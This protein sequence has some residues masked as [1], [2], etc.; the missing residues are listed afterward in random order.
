MKTPEVKTTGLQ[1]VVFAD[2]HKSTDLYEALGDK[3]ALKIVSQIFAHLHNVVKTHNGQVIR[4]FGDEVLCIFEQAGD[5]GAAVCKMHTVVR[6]DP[7]LARYDAALRIGLHYGEVIVRE[8]DIYG[9]A[10][11]VAAR[12]VGLAE[13]NQIITTKDTLSAF[14]ATTTIRSRNLGK[15]GVKGKAQDLDFCEILWQQDQ[16]FTETMVEPVR[17]EEN[18][19]ENSIGL[20]LTYA[21]TFLRLPANPTPVT[22]GRAEDNGLV[23]PTHMVSRVHATVRFQ[24]GKFILADRSTNGLFL[25]PDG[26]KPI[27]VHRDQVTLLGEGEIVLG[28][29]LKR[30][31]AAR[32]R[33]AL[34]G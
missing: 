14:P 28:R 11:N 19:V 16:T 34:K 5:A 17:L 8:D 9:D 18:P 1:A 2:I 32:I 6:R 20:E 22:I 23:I 10:V 3:E 13:K 4:T 21:T 27:F 29:D 15:I 7:M 33:Y 26:S 24:A 25:C 30:T 12:A 31:D